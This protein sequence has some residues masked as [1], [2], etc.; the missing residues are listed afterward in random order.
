MAKKDENISKVFEQAKKEIVKNEIVFIDELV[1]YLPVSRST[2]YTYFPADS[3]N[4]DI[5]KGLIEENKI[6]IKSTMRKKW[7]KSDAPALQISLYKLLATDDEMSRLTI[8]KVE[9]K[10]DVT[11]V[12]FEFDTLKP[13]E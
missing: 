4:L 11:E 5:L 12:R 1:S 8:N 13:K 2:F 7:L 3:D 9:A 10:V 6:S